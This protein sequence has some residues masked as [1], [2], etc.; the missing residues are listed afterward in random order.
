MT[1]S[2]PKYLGR[3]EDEKGKEPAELCIRG[4]AGNWPSAQKVLKGSTVD[5]SR[6]THSADT[7]RARAECPAPAALHHGRVLSFCSE[8]HPCGRSWH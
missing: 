7:A 8:F 4:G 6:Y 5:D 1:D 3:A 2:I